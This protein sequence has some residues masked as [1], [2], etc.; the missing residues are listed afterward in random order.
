[1]CAKDF[2]EPK[3]EFLSKKREDIGIKHFNDANA[4]I[5]CSNTMDESESESYES[6]KKIKNFSCVWSH[7]CRHYDQQKISSYNKRTIY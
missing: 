7:D 5:E 6:F 2:S 1:M 3:Y 4:F